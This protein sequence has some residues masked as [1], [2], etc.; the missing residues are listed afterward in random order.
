M[1]NASRSCSLGRARNSIVA[2]CIVVRWSLYEFA[3]QLFPD[4]H[5]LMQTSTWLLDEKR[6]STTQRGRVVPRRVLSTN[7]HLARRQ[8]S[9]CN[10]NYLSIQEPLPRFC[11]FRLASSF[12]PLRSGCSPFFYSNFISRNNKARNPCTKR[13]RERERERIASA[14][15]ISNAEG[16]FKI[17]A[18]GSQ[19]WFR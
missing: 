16:R 6:N 1:R 19:R 18:T 3:T 5:Y 12:H 13:E 15:N 14:P 10:Q 7:L 4:T 17:D 9:L 8:M 11:I 2:R